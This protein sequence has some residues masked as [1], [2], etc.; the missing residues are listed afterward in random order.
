[1]QNRII[2]DKIVVANSVTKIGPECANRVIIGGSHGG[3]YATYLAVREDVR[4]VILN[5]AGFAKNNSGVAGADYCQELGFHMQRLTLCHAALEMQKV[6][7][8]MVLSLL[9]I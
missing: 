7:L 3:I 8:T 2:D 4:G 1:M 9:S 6:M 5:D